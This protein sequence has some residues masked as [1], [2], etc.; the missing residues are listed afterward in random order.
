MAEKQSKKTEEKKMENVKSAGPFVAMILAQTAQVGLI[1]VSKEAM[2]NGMSKYVFICYS[3]A[4]ASLILLP[5]SF[6]VH[7]Y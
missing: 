3:N 6:V 2:S 1:I 4:L 5:A 7:R